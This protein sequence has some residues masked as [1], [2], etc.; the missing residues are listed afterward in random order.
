MVP[1]KS[2]SITPLCTS[3]GIPERIDGAIVG[4]ALYTGAFTIGEALE[5]VAGADA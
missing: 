1:G 4:K 3:D 5:F 2:H